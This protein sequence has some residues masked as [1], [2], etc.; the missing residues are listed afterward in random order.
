MNKCT[1]MSNQLCLLLRM[2]LLIINVASFHCSGF[3]MLF[4]G[5]LIMS[6]KVSFDR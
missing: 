6:T 1:N 5:N 4:I 2:I 3:Q